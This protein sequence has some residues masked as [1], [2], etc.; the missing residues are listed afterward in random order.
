MKSAAIQKGFYGRANHGAQRT[1]FGLISLLVSVD[2]IVEV[3]FEQLIKGGSLGVSGTVEGRIATLP[4]SDGGRKRKRAHGS[5]RRNPQRTSSPGGG[6]GSKSVDSRSDSR[7]N[8]D[9]ALRLRP[10]GRTDTDVRTGS[11]KTQRL[12]RNPHLREAMG[13]FARE[14]EEAQYKLSDEA[15]AYAEFLKK[16]AEARRRGE[17]QA[18]PPY[19]QANLPPAIAAGIA[20]MPLGRTF[21]LEHL[22]EALFDATGHQT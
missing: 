16:V 14:H 7:G 5:C 17:L 20:D 6:R 15:S 8:L 12:A 11:S 2:I 4:L 21:G 18:P 3:L 19:E 13:R 9:V 22:R 1:R 10:F